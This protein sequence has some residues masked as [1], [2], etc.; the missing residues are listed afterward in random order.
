MN[1]KDLYN[2]FINKALQF[3][4]RHKMLLNKLK[5]FPLFV[6]LFYYTK[7][8]KIRT[9]LKSLELRRMMYTSIALGI[10]RSK[11]LRERR[12]RKMK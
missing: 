9:T 11:K 7:F 5:N 8:N 2:K 4:R 12:K 6:R 3:D 10:Y 1:E